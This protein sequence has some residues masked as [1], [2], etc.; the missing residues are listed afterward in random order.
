PLDTPSTTPIPAC[1][2][3]YAVTRISAGPVVSGTTLISGSAC[4]DCYV[5]AN[6]PFTYYFYNQP[7]TSVKV[8]DNGLLSFA[9]TPDV[10]F[11]N[12]CIPDPNPR[13]NVI[14]ALWRDLTMDRDLQ[15]C[16]DIGCGVFTSVSGTAPNRI[17]NIEWRALSLSMS[18]P[19]TPVYLEVRLYEGQQ[20]WDVI[21][22][23]LDTT[24]SR[25]ATVGA[26][27][28]VTGLVSVLY[29][30]PGVPSVLNNGDMLTYRLETICP[31][32]TTTATATR[33]APPTSTNT[34]TSTPT[35]P[36]TT[37]TPTATATWTGMYVAARV[38]LEGRP[39]PP[40]AVQGVSVT[41]SLQ[42]VV[43]GTPV[44]YTAATNQDGYLYLAPDLPPGDYRWRVKNAQTLALGGTTSLLSGQNS[45]DLGTM[46]E[47][48]AD[49][50]N[51]VNALD[52][53]IVKTSFGKSIGQ[54]GYDERA[55]F[56]GDRAVT[57]Q[58]F[59]LSRAHFS[60]CGAPLLG[61]AGTATPSPTTTPEVTA[62][63][64]TDT[65]LIGRVVLGGRTA[66][67]SARQSVS[68]TLSL[69]PVG[70]GTA[71]TYTSVT[72][73]Y[74]Y[75]TVTT[76]LVPGPYTWRIKNDQTLAISGTTTLVTGDNQVDMG[77]FK[78]GDADDSNCV[79]AVDFIIT[80][81]T[82]G[83]SVGQL[84]YDARA[85]FT[86]D[87]AVSTQDFTLLKT[88]FNQCGPAGP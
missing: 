67:P 22:S 12:Y 74:G 66:P 53:I 29:Q 14:Y 49:N 48:D 34:P 78:E 33:T 2:Q 17:F 68:V 31:P 76:G 43:G 10:G 61:T 37:D 38:L 9:G 55:D 65:T 26:Q 30:C 20:K 72:D 63:P 50:N 77:V 15:Q 28:D 80:K 3:N 60:Q 36:V 88:N 47:G 27:Q 7:F 70:G 85:D 8:V 44:D 19:F 32:P 51:C 69:L 59:N 23:R 84:G 21:Y 11:N 64:A 1:P 57:L 56:T 86:G 83:K 87:G 25:N 16:L 79:N 71:A 52:F 75:M 73:D 24:D 18:N 81:M 62:T 42:P 41:L 39:T 45:L 6:L 82:Y 4:D 40:S 35:A 46:I 5:V 54:P 13:T 58:D